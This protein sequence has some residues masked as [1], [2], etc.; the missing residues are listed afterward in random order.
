LDNNIL[1]TIGQATDKDYQ[2]IKQVKFTKEQRGT[3]TWL[4][5]F[6]I[7]I[8]NSNEKE[9]LKRIMKLASKLA[10]IISARSGIAIGANYSGSQMK[11]DANK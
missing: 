3:D 11:I 8:Y 7:H 2:H 4:T 1:D 10:D 9:A 5:G 6:S